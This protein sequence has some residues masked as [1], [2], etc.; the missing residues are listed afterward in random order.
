[1]ALTDT[2]IKLVKAGDAD[3]K[4]ADEKGLYL[5]ITP[6]GSKLW[7]LKYRIDGK[8][9]KLAL[10]SY[11][12]VGLKEARARRDA[13][14]TAAEARNDPAAAKRASPENLLRPIALAQSQKNS[15]PSWKRRTRPTLPSQKPVGCCRSFRHRWA[16]GQS[17]KSHCMSCSPC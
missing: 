13:A 11:P 12:D 10:G 5:L 8:E 7:R 9:K 4:L 2:A 3:R 17:P 14:R 6:G 16:N 15:S 1:M